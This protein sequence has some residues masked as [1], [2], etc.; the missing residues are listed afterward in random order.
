MDAKLSSFVHTFKPSIHG[1]NLFITIH[2]LTKCLIKTNSL[3]K[4]VINSTTTNV[5]CYND[6][7]GSRRLLF[8]KIKL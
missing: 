3:I 6:V 7:D 4:L 5:P 8:V 2:I 1:N